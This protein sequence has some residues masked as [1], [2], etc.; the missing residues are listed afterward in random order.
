MKTR[1]R[2][3]ATQAAAYTTGDRAAALDALFRAQRRRLWAIAYRL[4]GSAADAEDVVQ[5]T[6]A[7]LLQSAPAE[8]TQSLGPWLARVAT[9]LGIDALRRRR[10]R[11]Y[12]GPWL[13]QPVEDPDA[14][15]LD[16]GGRDAADPERRYGLAESA[17]FAFLVALEALG[18]RQRAALLLRDVLGCTAQEAAEL[19]GTSEANV[20]V[21]HLRARRA[22][23]DYDRQRAA[24]TPELVRR[25]REA[26]EELARCLMAQDLAG[27][28]RLFSESIRTVTDA[29]GEYTALAAPMEGRA[30][31]ARFYL[32]AA[33]H[34][35]EG[36]PRIEIRLA[37][38]LPA[39]FIALG[40]PVR[41]QAPRTLLRCELGEDG[42]IREI[43]SVLAPRKL[44][45]LRFPGAP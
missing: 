3:P 27:L 28:E 42:R 20:R 30:R 38:G 33:L 19:L 7:R 6:F 32:A 44:A 14:E 24:P 36:E 17:S 23:A 41:R 10:R 1:H 12:M 37:N 15:A 11:G 39:L 35:R 25:H 45:A 34:R 31:V 18:P 43:H 4:T 2:E 5:E 21:L 8:A 9:N 40:R 29:A 22:L 13:P 16:D 26:L